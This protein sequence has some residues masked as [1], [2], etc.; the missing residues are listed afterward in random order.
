MDISIEQMLKAGVHFGHQTRFWNPKMEKYIF[1]DRNKVHIINLEKTLECLNPAVEFCK[2]LSASNNRILF[3]GTKRAARRVIKEEA[4]RCNMPFINYR[5]LGGMLTNYKTVRS[6]IRRLEILNTQEEEGKFADLTK[7]E[8]LGIRREME[9]LDRSI[10]GIKNI[11]GLPEALF[12]VD[13]ENEKIAIAEAK[14]M[15]IPIIGIVDT[16]SN[17]DDV[18]F[19]IPGNDDAIRSI[20][21]ISRIISNACL[22]G[23]EMSG[24]TRT[25]KDGPVVVK[26]A[27]QDEQEVQTESSNQEETKESTEEE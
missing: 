18:D 26:K 10:G 12:V 22:E 8:V 24:A 9:K 23:A 25:S 5:W 2:K 21:L 11:G 19:I 16:N 7:K 14:K 13:V 6:S 17:P 27:S 3:V 1:G 20:S 15:G 4:E